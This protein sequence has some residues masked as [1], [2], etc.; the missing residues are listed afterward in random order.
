MCVKFLAIVILIV[1]RTGR[2]ERVTDAPHI[3]DYRYFLTGILGRD[4]G[5]PERLS[6]LGVWHMPSRA[7]VKELLF[8]GAKVVPGWPGL[9]NQN[10]S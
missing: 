3:R 1:G 7:R 2:D 9:R 6:R 4:N 8:N 10:R 5:G